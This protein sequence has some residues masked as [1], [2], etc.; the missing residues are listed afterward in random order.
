MVNKLWKL[1]KFDPETE[2]L[3]EMSGACA[4]VAGRYHG[5]VQGADCEIACD[6]KLPIVHLWSGSRGSFKFLKTADRV[7]LTTNISPLYD[8][9]Q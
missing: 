1:W 5:S 8:N 6:I 2:I 9:I 3:C 7:K 4:R